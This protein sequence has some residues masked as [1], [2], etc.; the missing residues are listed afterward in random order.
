MSSLP[1]AGLLP[2]QFGYWLLAIR[3]RASGEL[4]VPFGQR[5]RQFRQEGSGPDGRALNKR[6]LVPL[7]TNQLRVWIR[8]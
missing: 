2:V 4:A 1:S 3:R 8:R 5:K 6:A 7:R